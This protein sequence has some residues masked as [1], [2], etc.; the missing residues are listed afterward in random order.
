MA[1]SK[2]AEKRIRVAE[3]KR[4]R[5][6]PLRSAAKTYEKRAETAIAA[7]DAETAVNEVRLAISQLD[8]VAGKG[9]IHP[10]NAARRKSRLMA[11]FNKLTAT[12]VAQV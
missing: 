12:P 4:A 1:N 2:S 8:K 6:K 9:V 3:R 7:G 5:N 10:N 11:K